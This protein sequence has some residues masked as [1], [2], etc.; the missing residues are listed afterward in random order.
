MSVMRL[1]VVEDDAKLARVLAR[2]LRQEG[3]HVDLARTGDDALE[4]ATGSD[5]DALV[6][7]VMLPGLDG[8]TVCRSLRKRDRRM[9]VLML[10]ARTSVE[11]RIRGLDDGADDYL[12]KPF[13]FG[14]LVARLRALTRRGASRPAPP[15]AA[16]GQ[17][18][19]GR[20]RLDPDVSRAALGERDV[21]LTVREYAVLEFLVRHAGRVV[22]RA[23]LLEAVWGPAFDGSG[24]V[25]DVYVGYVRRKLAVLDERPLIKTVRGSGFLVER[26]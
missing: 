18:T 26:P 6:L 10:T 3:Y 15:A 13:D 25:V 5:Y 24:N 9:P 4:Q 8:F 19:L 2:G 14:E 23:E 11:D 12:V 20:L 21:E 1:L 16:S 22:S 17:L 7:D